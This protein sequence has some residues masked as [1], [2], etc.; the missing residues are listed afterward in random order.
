MLLALVAGDLAATAA[1][2]LALA[3]NASPWHRQVLNR[4]HRLRR[5]SVF[6]WRG[7]RD[8]IV[9]GLVHG[10][11]C[12][13]AC[14]AWMLVPLVLSHHHLA[15]MLAVGVTSLADRITPP[16]PPRWHWPAGL[17]LL[18]LALDRLRGRSQQRASHA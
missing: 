17:L 9:Y 5:L 15:V 10:G 18:Y 1:A 16:A 2:A 6:G 8:A 14:W 4:G 12:I 7:D 3:W 13:A 11:W